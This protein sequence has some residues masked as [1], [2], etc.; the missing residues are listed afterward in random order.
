MVV[1]VLAMGTVNAHGGSTVGGHLPFLELNKGTRREKSMHQV[2]GMSLRDQ[3][4]VSSLAAFG[5]AGVS[6][7]DYPAEVDV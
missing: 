5:N 6:P 7:L 4:P 3:D 2:P 1:D